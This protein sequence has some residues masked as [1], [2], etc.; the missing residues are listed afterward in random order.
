MGVASE[1]EKALLSRNGSLIVLVKKLAWAWPRL[2]HAHAV[3][4]L[5]ATR[6]LLRNRHGQREFVRACNSS[7]Y[8]VQ[9]VHLSRVTRPSVACNSSIPWARTTS[10]RR[11]QRKSLEVRPGRIKLRSVR[12]KEIWIQKK[13]EEI[14]TKHLQG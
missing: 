5:E 7:T 6:A 8:R 1:Y 13:M 10:D 9:L 2:D 14:G 12:P 11:Q 4:V 3:E